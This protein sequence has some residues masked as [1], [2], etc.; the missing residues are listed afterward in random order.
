MENE[1]RPLAEELL[2]LLASSAHM[3]RLYPASSP[4]PGE[5]ISKFVSRSNEITT[6]L[7]SLRFVVEPRCFKAGEETLAAGYNQ[8]NWLAETL[9]AMQ[10]GQLILA[11]GITHTEAQTFVHIINSDP[12]SVRQRGVRTLLTGAGVTHIAVIEISLRTSNET[13]ILGLDLVNVPLDDIGREAIAA[14]EIWART[15]D[16]GVGHDDVHAAISRLEE[17]TRDIAAARIAEALLQLDEATRLN[18][19]TLSL[20]ADSSGRR[21]QGMF[22]VVARMRPAALAR[23]LSLA[24]EHSN[25]E[26]SR[27]MSVLE[28]PTEV[29]E[30]ISL[31]LAPS[32]RSEAECGVP[33]DP[34]VHDMAQEIA[35]RENSGDLQ[36]QVA[37]A[38]PT[39]AS[40]RA[41]Q[42]TVAISRSAPSPEAVR[43]IGEAL[44]PAARDGAFEATREA[45]RRLDEL[46]ALP[47]LALE[48]EHARARLQDPAVLFDVCRAPMTNAEAA[49]AGEI[50]KV[51]GVVGAEAL[52]RFFV[53]ASEVQ[54]SLFGPVIRSMG[55]PLLTAASRLIRTEDSATVIKILQVLPIAGDKRAIPIMTQALENLDAEIRRA[56]VRA[57]ADMPGGEGRF[58][59][60]N[61][62]SHWDP[63]TRRF[64]IREIGRTKTLEAVP[65]LIRILEDINFLE[66]NHE[67]KKEVIKSLELLGSADG[68]RVLRRWANRRFVFGRKN[69]ELRFLAQRA[70]AHMS[71]SNRNENK[72]VD[73]S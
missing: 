7:G 17:A 57:L 45:L 52:L 65:A 6:A 26:P 54:R 19:L 63:E 22:E 14:A 66:R 12:V 39:L 36:R 55:E 59:L 40:G 43:A 33:E 48:I 1:G 15:A 47:E 68:Q 3:S 56:A 38:S 37:L 42:T 18:V 41:L 58:A 2:R 50:I 4:L 20:R 21:M 46:A 27:L 35:K 13:G 67:L 30:Q 60:A 32:P 11:P 9:H 61:A 72:G 29:L 16:E 69:K 8:V 24:A 71:D 10:V 44:A 31:L 70:L 73:T 64:V 5:A 53:E 34:R 23:L 49:M 51:A 62:V 28:L 25:V